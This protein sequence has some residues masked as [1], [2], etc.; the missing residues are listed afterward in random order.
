MPRRRGRRNVLW[1]NEQ[2]PIHGGGTEFGFFIPDERASWI[3][4]FEPHGY[5]LMF[6][7]DPHVLASLLHEVN[8]EA[9]WAGCSVNGNPGEERLRMHVRAGC[10]DCG[11]VAKSLA[12]M[13]RFEVA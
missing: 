13:W 8:V 1:W 4:E 11:G 7:V 3:W 5:Y 2:V 6:D 10:Y 9:W 12:R